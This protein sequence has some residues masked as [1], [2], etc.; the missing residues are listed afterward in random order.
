[1]KKE[2]INIYKRNKHSIAFEVVE[3]D[4]YREQVLNNEILNLDYIAKT[5]VDNAKKDKKKKNN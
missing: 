4:E 5:I 3:W 2:S 1:V